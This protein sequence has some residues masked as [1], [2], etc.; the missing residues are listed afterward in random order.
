MPRFRRKSIE[1]K[2]KQQ[3]IIWHIEEIRFPMLDS[4]FREQYE[5]LDSNGNPITWEQFDWE[6]TNAQS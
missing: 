6:Q 2:A 3:G 1:V 4:V 5:P